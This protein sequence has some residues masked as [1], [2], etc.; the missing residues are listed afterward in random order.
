VHDP[1]TCCCV[2]TGAPRVRVTRSVSTPVRSVYHDAWRRL[3]GGVAGAPAPV[4]TLT[5]NACTTRLDRRTFT[6]TVRLL[7]AASPATYVRTS[8]VDGSWLSALPMRTAF[9][10]LG[11]T[12]WGATGAD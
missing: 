3:A 10:V 7:P 11:A 5:T 9:Q 6:S 2:A 4:C 12:L 8:A 1:P